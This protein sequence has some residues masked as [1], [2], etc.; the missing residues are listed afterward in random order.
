MA[1]DF[2][3]LV[4][5]G[6]VEVCPYRGEGWRRLSRMPPSADGGLI[7]LGNTTPNSCQTLTLTKSVFHSSKMQTENQLTPCFTWTWNVRDSN[8]MDYRQS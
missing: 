5:I 7:Q 3:R 6:I 2:I 4:A 8:Y 1:S